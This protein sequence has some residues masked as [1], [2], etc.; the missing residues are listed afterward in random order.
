MI[1]DVPV[2]MTPEAQ[3]R[4][5]VE[6][7]SNGGRE[8]TD[9]YGRRHALLNLAYWAQRVVSAD[10]VPRKPE[11]RYRE[12]LL[13]PRGTDSVVVEIGSGTRR[14]APHVVNLDIGPFAEVDC[15]ADGHL[16][17]LLDAT[18]D[19]VWIDTVLEHVSDPEDMVKEAF[20]ITRPGGH[21][22]AVVPWMH[23][24]HGYPSDFSRYSI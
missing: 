13:Y 20:R 6:L 2:L 7:S 5:G 4:F 14:L 9:R 17:P 15:I 24:Y 12:L 1:G 16:L 19:T 11:R 10:Y 18:A 21:I 23:P 22:F 8:M 3:R